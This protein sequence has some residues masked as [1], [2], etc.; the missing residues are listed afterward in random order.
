MC[1]SLRILCS[2][3][4]TSQNLVGR[5]STVVPGRFGEPMSI[6]QAEYSRSH[7]RTSSGRPMFVCIHGW[8][9]NERDLADMMKYVAPYNDFASLRAPFT[10][11]DTGAGAYSW[12]H[13]SVPT[14]ADLDRDIFA[15]ATAIDGWVEANIPAERAVVPIGF[16][17]GG[18]LAIHL[19]RINPERYRAV[20]SLSGFLAPGKVK[21]SAPAD[22]RLAE[23]DI[24]VF[25]G[26]GKN[27][28]VIPKY[29]L[30]ATSAWLDEHSWLT[31]KSYPGLDHSVS[32]EEFSDLRQWLVLNNIS[33]GVL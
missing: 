28:T 29:E 19:L 8:G 12:F 30:F 31:A 17:Q 6:T 32:L 25:Y 33:S 26:Y 23:R 14:G 2:M 4:D 11:S 5:E 13:D 21:G 16:S 27:D 20:I 24:P 9:S 22:E 7:G 3:S 1:A 10:L 15:A 18:A